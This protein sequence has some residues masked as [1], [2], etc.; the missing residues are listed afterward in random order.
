MLEGRVIAE[1]IG[2]I[3]LKGKTVPLEVMSLSGLTSNA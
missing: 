1:S 3:P 2:E